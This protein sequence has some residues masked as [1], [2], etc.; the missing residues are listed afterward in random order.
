V[1]KI[2]NVLGTLVRIMV[3]GPYPDTKFLCFN[4]DVYLYIYI[5]M[6]I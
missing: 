1:I 5:A 2:A 4:S 3:S 6:S